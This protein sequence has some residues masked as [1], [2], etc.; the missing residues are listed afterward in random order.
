MIGR[1]EELGE[2]TYRLDRHRRRIGDRL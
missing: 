1:H 2:A